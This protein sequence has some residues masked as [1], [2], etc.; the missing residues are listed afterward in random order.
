MLIRSRGEKPSLSRTK[1]KEGASLFAGLQVTLV[2]V[3]AAA[4]KLGEAVCEST[5][6]RYT[7]LPGDSNPEVVCQ[8]IKP[9]GQ[10]GDKQERKGRDQ[11]RDR[12]PQSGWGISSW[13]N[14]LPCSS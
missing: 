4:S 11:G 2:H 3:W 13:N 5:L 9:E 10:V 1:G 6:L 7:A 8:P 14:L 12:L